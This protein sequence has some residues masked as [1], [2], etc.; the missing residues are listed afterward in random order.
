MPS[1]VTLFLAGDVMTARGI[2][3]I[4]PHPSKPEL[5]EPYVHSA[6]TY[7]EL[8][9]RVHGPVPMPVEPAYVWG[10]ALDI[11]EHRA[12]VASLVNL[13]TSVTVSD[14]YWPWKAI[15][16]RMHPDNVGC[17]TTP[18][19]GVCSLANNHALD[20]DRRGLIE[21]VEVLRHAG[22]DP[23]GAGR[24]LAEA[25]RPVR[26]ELGGGAGLLAFGLGASSA[27]I[28]DDW[29]AS[30]SRPGVVFVDEL[31]L[32]TAEAVAAHVRAHKSAG[33]IAVVSIHWGSNWGYEISA[34]QVAF[35]RA[36]VRGGVDV[37][38]GHSSHH[39]RS[40]EV[41]DG[42]LILYGCGDLV[43]DYEGIDGH[44]DFRGDIGGMYFAEI[45]PESGRL[46][47]LRISPVEMR[48]FRLT[49]APEAD[50]DWLCE[51]LNRISERFGTRFTR[52]A[53]SELVWAQGR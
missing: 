1:T 30:A 34:D 10:D 51:R 29:A 43:S 53:G 50:A 37:V 41:F 45:E 32:A 21:T 42:K 6:V 15:H 22:I 4:L 19:L 28:P 52:A 11:L 5:R 17:L 36:L 14:A 24:D 47:D 16:H 2:D 13:E 49:R 12:P 26:R 44:G 38:H 48:R 8:A 7:V 25:S 3:Q 23:I 9:I 20:F 18:K 35:A 46:A 31:S 27:G 33:D 40:V 39:V